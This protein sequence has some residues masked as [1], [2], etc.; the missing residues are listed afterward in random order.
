[1]KRSAAN[2]VDWI[3]DGKMKRLSVLQLTCLIVCLLVRM[4]GREYT[5]RQIQLTTRRKLLSFSLFSIPRA[6]GYSCP[7]NSIRVPTRMTMLSV[8]AAVVV[9]VVVVLALAVQHETE[10]R[11]AMTWRKM[12]ADVSV[13]SEMLWGVLSGIQ[14]E[15]T[16]LEKVLLHLE[17]R[18]P[19]ERSVDC[20]LQASLWDVT[21][22]MMMQPMNLSG[23]KKEK[24]IF[25]QRSTR[26]SRETRFKGLEL[27]NGSLWKPLME[28][29]SFFLRKNPVVRI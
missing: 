19:H 17:S 3:M 15:T 21:G 23:K 9:V 26:Y 4:L 12:S 24:S 22:I 16:V 5:Q 7:R 10:T 18:L 11:T 2:S 28:I 25:N 27:V 29:I 13:Y 6:H 1:M 8:A 14:D 20:P